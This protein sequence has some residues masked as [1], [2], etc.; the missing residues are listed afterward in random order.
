[1]SDL[2][3]FGLPKFFATSVDIVCNSPLKV[4]A[5]CLQD[6]CQYLP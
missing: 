3:I 2:V 5:V 1:M 4:A 6:N